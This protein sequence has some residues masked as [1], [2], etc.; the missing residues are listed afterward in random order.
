MYST[1]CFTP[2]NLISANYL[3]KFYLLFLPLGSTSHENTTILS[4]IPNVD[5]EERQV[6]WGKGDALT[7]TAEKSCKIKFVVVESKL[8]PLISAE[9]L[10]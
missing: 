1:I 10:E 8:L 2:R 5:C 4:R 6:C 3:W 7:K 9:K